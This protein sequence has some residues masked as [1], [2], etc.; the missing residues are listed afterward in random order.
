M[1]PFTKNRSEGL[2]K[3]IT[4]SQLMEKLYF[5]ASKNKYNNDRLVENGTEG[6]PMTRRWVDDGEI[7]ISEGR[8]ISRRSDSRTLVQK[9]DGSYSLFSKIKDKKR[10]VGTVESD[11]VE[12]KY[13]KFG[14]QIIN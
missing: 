11:P 12:I 4:P 3:P 7:Y 6:T 10:P 5:V 2:K 8:S 9:T 1:F 13:D 14:D